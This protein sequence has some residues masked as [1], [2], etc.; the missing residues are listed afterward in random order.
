VTRRYA[1]T[2][3]GRVR[4]VEIEEIDGGQY[5]VSVDGRDRRVLL[6]GGGAFLDGTRVVAP[7]IDGALPRLTVSLGETAFPVEV[8]DAR[9]AAVAA[10]IRERPPA[11]GK[12]SV[13]A[14]IPGRVV[15]VLVKVGEPVAAG[16]GLA[17]LE[18][19][20]MENEI[21]APR[22]GTVEEIGCQ[23]GTLVETGQTLIILA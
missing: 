4:A 9:A 7:I 19:M 21:R 5:R 3:G 10:A 14:P 8:A 12:T 1:V 15:R 20:K 22:D 2:V 18:A 17:V 6:L 11:A 23:E 16:R 13:R